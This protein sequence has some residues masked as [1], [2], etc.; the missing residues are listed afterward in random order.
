LHAQVISDYAGATHLVRIEA[1]IDLSTTRGA[2]IS[3]FSLG[4][5]HHEEAFAVCIVRYED[6]MVWQQEWRGLTHLIHGR[7]QELSR[8]VVEGEETRTDRRTA[9]M[10]FPNV[11]DY[12]DKYQGV[13]SVVLNG[14]ETEAGVN[15]HQKSTASGTVH[16]T[17]WTVSL[18]WLA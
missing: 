9:Y 7:A 8:L 14:L 15:R 17:L 2:R 13:Q 4:S 5:E 12:V 3:W 11:L 10:L 6:P 18:T 1:E 16:H